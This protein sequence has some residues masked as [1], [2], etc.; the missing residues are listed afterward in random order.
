MVNGEY[1]YWYPAIVLYGYFHSRVLPPRADVTSDADGGEPV[2]SRTMSCRV[3]D[4]VQHRR[5]LVPYQDPVRRHINVD[6]SSRTT[7]VLSNTAYRRS[8]VGC[9]PA[10]CQ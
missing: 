1:P 6:L 8:G 7:S 4:G 10:H 9:P 5:Y 2:Y 3:R